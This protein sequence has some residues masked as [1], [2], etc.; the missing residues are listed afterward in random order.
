MLE[1]ELL[2]VAQMMWG[3]S[4]SLVGLTITLISGYLI[5]AYI[6]GSDM[7]HSQALIINVLYV[8]F[9]TFLILSMLAF[10][11]NAGEVDTIALE[12]STQ[13]TTPARTDLAYAVGFFMSFCVLASLKFMWDVRHPK[14]E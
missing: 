2:E 10:S 13:R 14:T 9:A 6:A 7:T 8:G 5:V 4:I 1:S 3:N 11:Q 12:M